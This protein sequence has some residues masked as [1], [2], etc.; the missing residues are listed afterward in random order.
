MRRKGRK[1]GRKRRGAFVIVR[2]GVGRW[3]ETFE[4]MSRSKRSFYTVAAQE[5]KSR[6][7]NRVSRDGES[8]S[9]AA[10]LSS[11]SPRTIWSETK[12]ARATTSLS[13]PRVN[14]FF[15]SISNLSRPW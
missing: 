3:G 5:T 4:S 6:K 11:K 9:D 7:K 2:E 1:R 10:R 8:G 12:P 15:F 13:P 14:L